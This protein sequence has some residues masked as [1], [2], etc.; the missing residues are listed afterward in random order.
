MLNTYIQ[1]WIGLIS[2]STLP[3]CVLNLLMTS[4]YALLYHG[5]NSFM[6]LISEAHKMSGALYMVMACGPG[7]A[8]KQSPDTVVLIGT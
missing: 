7:K 3:T 6:W 1:S 5:N 2:S 4:P 8:D